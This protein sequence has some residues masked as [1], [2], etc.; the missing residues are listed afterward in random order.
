MENEDLI[1]TAKDILGD[2]PDPIAQM[3]AL[4][5]K[6]NE[7]DVPSQGRYIV[8]HPDLVDTAKAILGDEK[9]VFR[10]CNSEKDVKAEVRRFLEQYK[11]MWL[12]MP[13]QT[14][15]GVSGTPDFVGCYNGKAFAIET[16]FG[17]AKSTPMQVRQQDI[18]RDAGAELFRDI[19]ETK[20]ESFADDWRNFIIIYGTGKE[21]VK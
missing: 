6:L 20:L 18:M 9:F 19:N 1:K 17:K 8:V 2:V 3:V 21:V 10:K 12:F 16:K 5:E 14:G 15:F 13:V 4:A 11:P 7:M